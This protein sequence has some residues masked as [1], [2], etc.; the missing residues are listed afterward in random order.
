MGWWRG[1]SNFE[2][3]YNEYFSKIYNYIFYRVL[4]KETAE[5]LTS[6]LFMK[7]VEKFDTFDENKASFSTWIYRIASNMV[8]DYFRSKKI[9]LSLDDEENPIDLP[10]DFEAEKNIIQSQERKQLYEALTEL[11]DRTRDLL[12]MKYFLKMSNKEISLTKG[13]N[14]STVS[15]ICLRGIEKL[16]KRLK[17]E[18]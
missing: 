1:L 4:N 5:D 10:V 2:T 17:Y 12:S 16:K 7:L 8:I 6:E 11:D 13:I 18:L 9:D 14:E 3:M 15:T